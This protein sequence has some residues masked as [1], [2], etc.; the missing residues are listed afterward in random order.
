MIGMDRIGSS[1]TAVFFGQRA[2]DDLEEPLPSI[3]AAA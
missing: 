2:S 3:P 1:G